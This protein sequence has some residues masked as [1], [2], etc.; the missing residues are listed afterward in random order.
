LNEIPWNSMK[1]HEIFQFHWILWKWG[2]PSIDGIWC[3]SVL[4]G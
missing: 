4:T 3:N 1:F 2:I